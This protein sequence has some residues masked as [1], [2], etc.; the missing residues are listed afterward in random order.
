MRCPFCR[1][2]DTQVLETRG[3]DPG[4]SIRRRRRCLA[5]ARRFTTFERVDWVLPQ[6]VKRDGAKVEF[7]RSKLEASLR[8][9][10]RKRPV[11]HEAVQDAVVR[12][13][14]LLFQS[15]E[16]EVSSLHIGELVMDELHRLDQVAYIRFASVYRNFSDI[17]AFAAALD[18]IKP[19]S[20]AGAGNGLSIGLGE[21]ARPEGTE[22]GILRV[23]EAAGAPVSEGAPIDLSALQAAPVAGSR[24]SGRDLGADL[25]PPGPVGGA[26]W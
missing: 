12:I 19:R 9:A 16:R 3:N 8:L 25:H 23:R 17:E 4:E 20:Q 5:C 11:P 18:Q 2:E 21:G 26:G 13:E 24:E 7:V 22:L 10:L 15:G 6:V 14:A 1:H